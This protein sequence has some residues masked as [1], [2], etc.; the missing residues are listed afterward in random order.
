MPPTKVWIFAG[1][2][3]FIFLVGFLV[4]WEPENT[5]QIPCDTG[6]HSHGNGPEHCDP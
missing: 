2:I 1:S 4:F 5:K 3:V 6:L